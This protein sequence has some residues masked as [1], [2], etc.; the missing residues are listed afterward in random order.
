[1]DTTGEGRSIQRV[2]TP[3]TVRS[4]SAQLRA[5]GV[6]PGMTLL[7]HASLSRLG[8]VVGGPVAVILALERV[9]TP[10]G[11]LVMPVH[12]SDLS[13]PA[14]WQNPP[15]PPEWVP[16][17]RAEMPAFRPDL[18]PTRGIGRIAE[19]FRKQDGVQ[20]S[21]HPTV[22]FAAWGRRAALIAADQPLAPEF[23]DDSPVG[24][25]YDM[26]GYVLL[27]GAEHD[28]NSSLHLSEVRAE[29]PG[30]P[31]QRQGAPVLLD[32]VRRWVT[33]E[34][35]DYD[36]DDFG[37]IGAAFDATGAATG[38]VTIGRIGAATCRLMRQRDL[39]DFGVA[40]MNRHRPVQ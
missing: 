36:D 19:T 40:W 4:L 25:V 34:D 29:W 12:S 38:T 17:I 24:R 35:V 10:E 6:Q 11:T 28:A 8:W 3:A 22:S 37:R 5:L 27:L 39:V 30:K 2:E 31:T 32:G 26:D 21:N 1:M 15:V 16:I 18:T 13:D 23:G 14:H 33:Y 9:L 7:V 20:R